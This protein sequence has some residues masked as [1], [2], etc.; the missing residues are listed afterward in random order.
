MG[1]DERGSKTGGHK[2][3]SLRH[4]LIAALNVV[5]IV[6][7]VVCT[8]AYLSE[9][10]LYREKTRTSLFVS[11]VE[12]MKRYAYT[13][14]SAE[15]GYVDNWAR[16]ITDNDMTE[17]EA[18]AFIKSLNTQDQRWA[19]IVDMETMEARS[20]LA[21][22]GSDAVDFY[23]Q[24]LHKEAGGDVAA[25]SANDAFIQT[26][27]DIFNGGHAVL[28]RYRLNRS[29]YTVVAVGTK[30]TLSTDEGRRD[31]LLLRLMPVDEVRK[32]WVFPTEFSSAEVGIINRSGS[33]VV[34]SASM[35]S[36]SFLDLIRA[37]NFQDDY[38]QVYA[39]HDRLLNTDSGTLYYYDSAGDLCCWYYS[40][41]GD[42]SQMDILG[43]VK[44]SDLAGEDGMWYVAVII[45]GGG[46][47][48]L[49]VVDG[50]TLLA[51]NRHLRVAVAAA[52]EANET[53]T[54]FLASMSH[55][56][57]TPM[58]AVLGMTAIA[59]EHVDEPE[60]VAGYLDKITLSGNHLLTLINDVLDISQIE[61]GR[62][63]LNPA[64]FSV[65][66][67]VDGA[68]DILRV[69]IDNRR[70]AFTQGWGEM[71]CDT[72]MGDKLRISQILINLLTNAVKYTPE[73]GS[74]SMSVHEEPVERDGDVL[75]VDRVRLVLVV[76]D[77]GMGMTEEFQKVMYD[78][79]SRATASQLNTVQGT[80]LGLAIVKRLVDLMEGAIECVSAPQHGT[81][82]TVT[83]ELPTVQGTRERAGDGEKPALQTPKDVHVLVAEDN[84]L[85]WEIV[86]ELL[87]SHGVTC[88]RAENGAVCLE[89]LKG[90]PAGTYDAVLMDVQMPVMNGLE[91]TRA[92]R[93]LADSGLRDIPVIAMTADAFAQDVQACLDAGMDAHISKPIDI[94]ATLQCMMR[95][96]NA[97]QERGKEE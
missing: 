14:I 15:Q 93:G 46:L 96:I 42:D 22:N 8:W 41:F 40:S 87:E 19:H 27:Q 29:G 62:M 82:F 75:G 53:K 2:R 21:V 16:Y 66:E 39:L 7:M 3:A 64:A 97:R 79:F 86:Q 58:N 25:A 63:A 13:Y 48:L 54:R 32:M 18:L 85:N 83:L 35:R 52:Q 84:D 91:A 6:A 59:K 56:I 55:D 44:A 60:R 78:S 90:A 71:A 12:T 34:P 51:V 31:Y 9:A 69:H 43:Y 30:V 49:M 37:Y 94:Q 28:G 5:I 95:L 1:K 73:G 77:T 81:R 10:H 50:L 89:K 45:I 72:L 76:E 47:V 20:T 88:E 61:S 26:M 11:S 38:R 74:V 70:I 92:I 24:A 23:E 68:V 33:Y 4:L 67:T 17:D 36:E 80:G 57:R 65:R